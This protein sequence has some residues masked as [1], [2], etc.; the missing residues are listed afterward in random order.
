VQIIDLFTPTSIPFTTIKPL[1]QRKSNFIML[2]K[3]QHSDSVQELSRAMIINDNDVSLIAQPKSLFKVIRII[4][5]WIENLVTHYEDQTVINRDQTWYRKWKALYPIIRSSKRTVTEVYRFV[6]EELLA[7]N[8]TVLDVLQYFIDTIPELKKY[9][10]IT[11]IGTE[12]V[13]PNYMRYKLSLYFT[14]YNDPNN[15]FASVASSDDNDDKYKTFTDNKSIM[16]WNTALSIASD[17]SI[18]DIVTTTERQKPDGDKIDS[19]INTPISDDSKMSLSDT[20]LSPSAILATTDERKQKL[21]K[22]SDDLKTVIAMSCKEE[23][24]KEMR[25]VQNDIDTKMDDLKITIEETI[26]DNHTKLEEIIGSV[27]KNPSVHHHRPNVTVPSDLKMNQPSPRPTAPKSTTFNF[28]DSPDNDKNAQPS[29]TDNIYSAN[30]INRAFQKSG[31]LVFH[32]DNNTYELRDGDFNKLKSTF[33]PIATKSDL[34]I[35]YKQLHGMAIAHNIF[36]STFDSLVPWDKNPNSITPTCMFTNINTEHNTVDAYRRMKSALYHKITQATFKNQE[37]KAIVEHGKTEQDGFDILYDLMTLCH[38]H[39][40]AITN[41]YRNTNEKPTFDRHDSIYS[42]CNKLQSWL[43]IEHI[44]NHI[45]TDDDIINMT[46]EQL[47]P[48]TR[49]DKAVESITQQLTFNDTFQ[50]QLGTVVFPEGLKLRNLPGTIMSYYSPSEKLE[51]FPT[52]TTDA[53]IN[54]VTDPDPMTALINSLNGRPS[55]ARESVDVF[56]QGCG[57]LGHD[58]FQS[59]CDFCAKQLLVTEFFKKFNNMKP[60]VIAKY[61]DHQSKIRAAKQAKKTS[62]AASKSS[63]KNPKKYRAT[64]RLLH[65]MLDSIDETGTDSDTFEDA[66]EEEHQDKSDHSAAESSEQE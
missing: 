66:N 8:A 31:T 19:K 50:R 53:T 16:T 51:L 28:S 39:L 20:K 54:K 14:R 47:R 27:L 57:Q 46:L 56:C 55:Y 36:L 52:D 33:T 3:T 34:I 13:N 35:Y 38:P 62:F 63:R 44:N 49:Y 65:D 37:Y 15:R 11:S 61:K 64:V 18:P 41:K 43:D 42:Y 7:P 2:R 4:N 12:E 22:K 45:H 17:A 30:S 29:K 10:T 24:E 48:D 40:V 9:Q 23:I 1:V 26:T 5:Q 21:N 58:V 6:T 32:Y 60:K 25:Q 59:G